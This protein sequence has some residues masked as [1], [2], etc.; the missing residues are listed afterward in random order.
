MFWPD[1]ASS[2]YDKLAM[3]WFEQND[4]N[5]VYKTANP[6]NCLELRVIETIGQSLNKK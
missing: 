3:E 4:V 6:P 1:L 2:H 5:I